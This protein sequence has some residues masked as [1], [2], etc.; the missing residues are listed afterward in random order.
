MKQLCIFAIAALAFTACASDPYM[1]AG[2]VA[3]AMSPNATVWGLY[4]DWD[5]DRD[6]RV[7][8]EEFD[9]RFDPVYDPWAGS[10]RLLT[11]AEMADRTWPWW[12][13]DGDGMIDSNEWSRGVNAW[14]F[15]GLDWRS[16]DQWDVNRDDRISLAEYRTGFA[17]TWSDAA[18]LDRTAMGDTWWGWWDANRDNRIDVDEWNARVNLGWPRM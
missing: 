4:H 1:G 10:D 2:T 6:D 17:G 9:R 18:T 7:T 13:V 12:D 16:L 5:A 3:P 8:R 15:E 11:N 14:R